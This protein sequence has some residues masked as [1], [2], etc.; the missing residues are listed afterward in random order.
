MYELL[1]FGYEFLVEFLPFLAALMVLRR[2]RASSPAGSILLPMLLA[3]YVIAVFNVT[4]AGTIY[5]ADRYFFRGWEFRVN[6]IPFSRDINVTGYVLNV[7]MFL[8]LGF[9]VPLIWE[10][11]STLPRTALVGLLFSLGIELSQ[12]LSFRGTDVDDLLMN[13]LGAVLGFGV[14]TVWNLITHSRFQVRG[15]KAR[16][17]PM[18]LLALY[19]GRF[20]LFNQVGLINL[21]YGF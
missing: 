3:L 2:R 5:T 6:L 20:L 16:E 8:P 1:A 18:Y 21:V 19:G 13:T 12:L 7:V 17:L 4:G 15:L 11:L 10:E 14:Y 9:L